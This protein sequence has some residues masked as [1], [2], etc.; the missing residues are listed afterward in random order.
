MRLPVVYRSIMFA[1]L[2]MM[3][4]SA[5]AQDGHLDTAFAPPGRPYVHAVQKLRSGN[6]LV[7]YCQASAGGI[8]AFSPDGK[9]LPMRFVGAP[10]QI[11]YSGQQRYVTDFLEQPDGKIIIIGGNTD[12]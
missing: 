10:L 9:E 6:I 3:M 4:S 5:K 8:M 12:P 7:G 11:E 2:V 1:A